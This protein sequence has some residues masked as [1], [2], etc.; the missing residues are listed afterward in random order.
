VIDFDAGNGRKTRV[1]TKDGMLVKV[2]SYSATRMSYPGQ[3]RP[4]ASPGVLDFLKLPQ[5]ARKEA[6][7]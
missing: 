3:M 5:T 2:F 7:V 6:R 4:A 1:A